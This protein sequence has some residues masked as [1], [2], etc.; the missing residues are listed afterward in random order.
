MNI[1][2]SKEQENKGD[3]GTIG[4]KTV[5][6]LKV[7]FIICGKVRNKCQSSKKQENK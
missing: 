5:R 3:V 1:K 2:A 6:I 4:A 7:I